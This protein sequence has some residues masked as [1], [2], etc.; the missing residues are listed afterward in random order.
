MA[1]GLACAQVGLESGLVP[2]EVGDDPDVQAVVKGLLDQQ[3]MPTEKY[4]EPITSA[5]EV[6]WLHKPRTRHPH[7][8]EKTQRTTKQT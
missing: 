4:P 2:V 3:K 5:Q 1:R 8:R 7:G 6:G